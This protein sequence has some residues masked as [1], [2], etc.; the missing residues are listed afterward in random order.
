MVTRS[1][2]NF[3]RGS[4]VFTPRDIPLYAAQ[5]AAAA[6]LGARQR[7]EISRE[8]YLDVLGL[9]QETEALRMRYEEESGLNELFQTHQPFDSPNGQQNNNPGGPSAQQGQSGGRPKGQ[10]DSTNRAAK[11]RGNSNGQ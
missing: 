9:D 11:G 1:K 7:S 3:K 6:I 4:L 8:T 10:K 5:N 2:G